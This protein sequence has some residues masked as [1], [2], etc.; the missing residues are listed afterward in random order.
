MK[1]FWIITALLVPASANAQ[2]IPP[3]APLRGDAANLADTMKFIEEKLPRTVNYML[4]VHDNVSGTDAPPTRMST[5][6]TQVSANAGRC[7]ISFHSKMEVNVNS[8]HEQDSEIFLKQVRGISLVQADTLQ[9]RAKAQAGHPELSVKGDPPIT[10]V[11]V[12]SAPNDNGERVKAVLGGG[13]AFYD[14]SLADRVLK[15]LQHAVAL[16]GGG[17]PETF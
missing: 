3:L 9:Q 4:Y 2:E 1:V 7:S 13:F 15:A 8:V 10:L 6:V 5:T 14:D 16:C 12:T 17:K 11:I